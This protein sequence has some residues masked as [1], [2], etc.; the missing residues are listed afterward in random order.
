MKL[1]LTPEDK[2]TTGWLK[3]KAYLEQ[4]LAD[5]REK[6]D[7]DLSPEKTAALR[8]EIRRVKDMLGVERKDPEFRPASV[9]N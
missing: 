3:V 2:S 8:G 6:N 5:L 9:T 7:A 4:S 1:D